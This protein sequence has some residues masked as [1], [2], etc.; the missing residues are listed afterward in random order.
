MSKLVW[1]MAKIPKKYNRK[2]KL[3][4]AMKSIKD[5]YGWNRIIT[6]MQKGKIIPNRPVH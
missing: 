2:A 6:E 1:D 5:L 4:G 3:H